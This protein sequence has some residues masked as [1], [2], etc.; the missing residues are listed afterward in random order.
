MPP[1]ACGGAY[2]ETLAAGVS[3][4]N[5]EVEGHANRSRTRV[6]LCRKSMDTEVRACMAGEKG[7]L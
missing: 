4:E 7:V 2:V 5:T 1:G 3:Q 6:Y